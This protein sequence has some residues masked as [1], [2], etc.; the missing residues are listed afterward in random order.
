MSVAGREFPFTLSDIYVKDW[1][2]QYAVS[3]TKG[4]FL[5]GIGLTNRCNYRCPFCYYHGEGVEE[6]ARDL[7]LEILEKVFQSCSRLS[8]VNFALEGEPLCYPHFMEAVELAAK[9]ADR[10]MLCTNGSLLT[11][12]LILKLAYFNFSLITL[13]INGGDEKSYACFNQGGSLKRFMRHASAATKTFGRAVVFH[14]V[15]FKENLETV[16]LL[17]YLA[18]EAGIKTL[19]L[20][21]LREH[22][23]ATHRGITRAAQPDLLKCVEEICDLAQIFGLSVFFDGSLNLPKIRTWLSER[24]ITPPDQDRPTCTLPWYYTSL[25]S[26]GKLFPCCGDFEPSATELSFDGIFNHQYLRML[27]GHMLNGNVPEACRSCNHESVCICR[28]GQCLS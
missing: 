23:A 8:G 19:S 11:E 18:K 13:S 21:C 27:R 12:K 1:E 16:K 14:T 17:P 28:E 20:A 22:P 7:S 9:Y 6:K 25:L 26:S 5:L 10:L 24:G 15:L 3:P 4:S 2:S